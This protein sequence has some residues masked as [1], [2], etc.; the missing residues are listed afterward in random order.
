MVAELV[1][2]VHPGLEVEPVVVRTRGDRDAVVVA[3][4][5]RG[6]GRLRRPRWRRRWPTAGPTP[7]C[8]RPRTCHR[9]C[10]PTSSSAPCPG[11]PIRATGWSGARSPGCRRVGSSPP[12][13]RAG[14]PSWPICGLTWSSPTCAA[15]WRGGW[16][17]RRTGS[18][19]AVVV[20]VA[21]MERLGW[22]GRLARRRSTPSTC[23]PRPVRVRSRCSAG[24]TT[25]RRGRG[26]RSIDDAPSHHALRAERAVLAALGGSC[27]APVGACAEAVAGDGAGSAPAGGGP[28]GERRRAHRGPDGAPGRRPRGASA[29][30]WPVR[31]STAAARRSTASM[32]ARGPRDR[33]RRGDRLPGRRGARRPGA[34]HPAG[35][36]AAGPGRRRPPRPAGQP[37]R[38]RPGPGLGRADRRGQGS[39]RGGGTGAQGRQD[40]IARLLVEHGRRAAVVVRLKGGDPSSSAVAARRSSARDGPA[41]PGRSCPGVTSAFGVPAVA[42]IPVTQRGLA[43]SV[44]VVTG[45]VGDPGGLGAAR[46]GTRWRAP[47][48]PWSSS[49]A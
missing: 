6:P 35:R 24:P 12:A 32:S 46:T 26:S 1:R 47:A 11:G 43:S 17:W 25:P 38:P 9:P 40:E 48:A 18:S 8:T 28:G 44:T 42:G 16:P 20:A 13:R 5:D 37:G 4:P 14:G 39:R 29:P 49:W 30:R 36:R 7:P 23:C 27:T 10:P 45:R 19:T 34:A 33:G 2:R 21:A 31:C 15:T 41:S 3:R 22:R